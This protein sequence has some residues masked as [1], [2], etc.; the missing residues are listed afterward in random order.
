M[1]EPPKVVEQEVVKRERGITMVHPGVARSGRH[2]LPVLGAFGEFIET[3]RRRS[4]NRM[5]L[6]AGFF[7]VILIAVVGAGLFIGMVLFDR[8]DR[9]LRTV[10][11]TFEDYK[12]ADA[13]KNHERYQDSGKVVTTSSLRSLVKDQDSLVKAQD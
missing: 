8:M 12:L 5:L 11:Q 1:Q 6:L 7:I 3:E 10:E 9:D 4:R 13:D 2:D